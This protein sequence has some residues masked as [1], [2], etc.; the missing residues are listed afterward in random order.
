MAPEMIAGAKTVDHRVDIYALGVVLYELLTGSLPQGRFEPPSRRVDVDVRIDEVVLRSLERDPHRRYQR[1][2]DLSRAVAAAGTGPAPQSSVQ[3]SDAVVP[4][5][6]LLP[7]WWQ[8]LHAIR[9]SRADH[10]VSGV[11]GGL[12]ASTPLPAWLWRAIFLASCLLYGFGVL[13]YV[14]LWIFMPRGTDPPR[15]NSLPCAGF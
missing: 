3:G 15:R 8:R 10:Q 5:V 4:A 12:G 14:V 6:S 9:L 13:V 1:A 7:L 2:E 11:C